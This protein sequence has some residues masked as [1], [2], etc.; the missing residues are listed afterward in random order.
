MTKQSG[1]GSSASPATVVKVVALIPS[2]V[3][4]AVSL[5]ALGRAAIGQPVWGP[6]AQTLPQAVASENLQEIARLIESGEDPDLPAWVPSGLAPD[7]AGP[8]TPLEVAVGRGDIRDAQ[9]LLDY[10]AS[11]EPRELE[12]LRCWSEVAASGGRA[13]EWLLSLSPAP[14]PDCGDVSLP[15][16][17]H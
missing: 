2:V 7:V 10:G 15:P 9:L 1:T 17:R 11:V 5:F 4:A 6:M 3:L 12:V 13:R 8:Y 16:G 14:W